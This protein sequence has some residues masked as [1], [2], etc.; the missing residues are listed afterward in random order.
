MSANSDQ[1]FDD[2]YY[3]FENA[4]EGID[5][6]FWTEDIGYML[7]PI[8]GQNSYTVYKLS[9]RKLVPDSVKA[10]HILINAQD[11][12]LEEAEHIADSL[13]EMLN[14]GTPM[15]ELAE[16]NSDD[17]AS[18]REGGDL[19]WFTEGIMVKPFNDAAFSSE[20]GSFTKVLTQFGY[21]IIEVTDRTKLI[22]KVQI[23]KLVVNAT[24]GNE[25]YA[26]IFNKANSFSIEVRDLESFNSVVNEKN[27]QRRSV[28]IDDKSSSIPG[29]VASRDIVRWA[30][31]AKEGQV[32]EAYDV[33]DA[34][35]VVAIE[36]VSDDGVAPFEKV[37][38]RVEHLAKQE[39]KAENFI[40]EFNGV[41]ASEISS[42][43]SALNLSVHTASNVSFANPYLPEAGVEPK[44]VGKVMSLSQGQLSVPIKGE[45]GVFVVQVDSKSSSDNLD[46]E[47]VRIEASNEI[48]VRYSQRE[49]LKALEKRADI[50][51]NRTVFY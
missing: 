22:E 2:T 18:A 7:G 12:S 30:K 25:T 13:L 35:V 43:A 34:F 47:T 26:N 5:S 4:P 46:I 45:T 14:N 28:T 27:I 24:P 38:N 42:I 10:S 39:K 9:D 33:G 8:E 41:N 15:E 31:E 11:R 1:R 48:H 19:G 37:K 32:S 44:V 51:D 3:S 50:K 23:A 6:S 20:I 17:V 49:F 21:H 29:L 36:N 40:K 16:E